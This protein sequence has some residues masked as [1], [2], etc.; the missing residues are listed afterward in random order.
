MIVIGPIIIIV[1][2]GIQGI[3]SKTD[4]AKKEDLQAVI[5]CPYCNWT[6][7]YAD[8]GRAKKAIAVHKRQC[9]Y[10]PLREIMGSLGKK[11]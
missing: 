8:E 10:N 3:E 2:N 4:T 1:N 7:T 5:S 6:D 9:A 11:R